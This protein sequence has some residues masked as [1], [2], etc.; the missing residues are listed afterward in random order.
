MPDSFDQEPEWLKGALR[1]P[2]LTQEE[3]RV[4]F[5]KIKTGDVDARKQIIEHYKWFVESIA[6]TF[7]VRKVP[8]EDLVKHGMAGLGAAI[9][10]FNP[11]KGFR[12]STYATYWIRHTIKQALAP[13]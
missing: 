3:E 7:K 11:D 13:D 2:P 8:Q 4:L 12:F 6:R 9:D 10:N 5:E 1:P